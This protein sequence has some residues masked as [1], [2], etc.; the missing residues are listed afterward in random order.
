LDNNIAALKLKKSIE[1]NDFI[2][3]ACLP[4]HNENLSNDDIGKTV[5]FGNSKENSCNLLTE[6]EYSVSVNDD[7]IETTSECMNF[8]GNNTSGNVVKTDMGCGLFKNVTDHW[9]L[10]GIASQLPHHLS[11]NCNVI[12]TN[13]AHYIAWIEKQFL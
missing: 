8:S 1:Y 10:I 11:E 2:Q 9:T 7:C 13:V 6:G 3:P 12:F 4:A 5:G